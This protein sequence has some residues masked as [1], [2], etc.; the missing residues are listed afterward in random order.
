MI[1]I[2]TVLSLIQATSLLGTLVNYNHSFVC[3]IN[4]ISHCL[5]EKWLLHLLHSFI[6]KFIQLLSCES[7]LLLSFDLYYV[8]VILQNSCKQ[9]LENTRKYLPNH[10][11]EGFEFGILL[12]DVMG[13]NC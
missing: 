6:F 11:L 12:S 2:A 5:K 9:I 3:Q 8:F 1:R 10:H 4:F 13:R 7:P